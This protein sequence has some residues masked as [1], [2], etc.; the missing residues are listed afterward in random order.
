MAHCP[1]YRAR[2]TWTLKCELTSTFYREISLKLAILKM[3]IDESVKWNQM[4]K[5]S[6]YES[7]RL[8][9]QIFHE[10][11]YAV[12]PELKMLCAPFD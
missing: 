3:A 4:S 1:L 5:L 8:R 2:A 11:S 7:L 9:V 10:L 6:A 12:P